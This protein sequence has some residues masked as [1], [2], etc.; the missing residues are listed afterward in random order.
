MGWKYLGGKT[1][2]EVT[3]DERFF[4]Q[5]LYNLIRDDVPGFVQK[6]NEIAGMNLPVEEEWEVGFEVCLYRDH[7]FM[8]DEHDHV[9][10]GKED[11]YS[12]KRTFD[13]CLFSH[14]HIVIIEAKAQQGF[15]PKQMDE[16]KQDR[17][18]VKEAIGVVKSGDGAG[19]DV[20]VDVVA[21]ASSKYL[22]KLDWVA[23]KDKKIFSG[24]AAVSWKKLA[25]LYRRNN[26]VG[27]PVLLRADEIYEKVGPGGKN[28]DGYK[29]GK[30][31]VAENQQGKIRFVGRNGGVK[32]K[33]FKGDI[34]TGQ[35]KTQ[36]YET[37]SAATMPIQNWFT[38]QE[39]ISEIQ[40]GSSNN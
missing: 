13:L 26:K 18:W 20:E 11:M 4:C 1:W 19:S 36:K 10:H 31:L 2:A 38:L 17:E 34:E 25:E 23:F 27:D 22:E 12:P 32:G 16:F 9:W 14:N 5:H 28:N 15:D 21:L 29:T 24:E 35:W 40:R 39:F 8:C 6:L 37:S 7:R 30:V 3:R 33:L